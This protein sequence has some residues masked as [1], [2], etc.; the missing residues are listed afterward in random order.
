MG[1]NE[2]D[3]RKLP[4]LEP[5]ERGNAHERGYEVLDMFYEISGT[6]NPLQTSWNYPHVEAKSRK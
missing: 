2:T 1:Q 5:S 3:L 4:V 6:T